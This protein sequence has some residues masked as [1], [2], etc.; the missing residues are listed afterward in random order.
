MQAL[1]L[2][3]ED[4]VG[5]NV[6]AFTF[7]DPRREVN[8][9][10]VFDRG[11]FVQ[12]ILGSGV[13]VARQDGEIPDP[14]VRASDAIEKRCEARVTL[15]QPTTWGDTV[16]LVVEALG[17]DVVPFLEGFALDDLGVQGCNTVDRVGGVAGDPCHADRVA[18][19]RCHVVDGRLF[20]ATFCHLDAEAT[21]DFADDFGDA[22]EQTVED[23]HFPGFESFGQNSV[24]RVCEGLGDDC[25][26][27]FPAELVLVHEQAHEFRN[28]QNRVSVVQLDRVVLREVAQILA[29]MFDVVVDDGLQ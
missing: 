6:N 7:L 1:D 25:P 14:F 28:S 15:L 10:G 20:Q 21:V 16:R 19:N 17:P 26:G 8:L 11:E 9:V 23:R 3:I 12:N 24:V 29:V 22:R 4:G 13:N 18:G 2:N 27:V 5:I